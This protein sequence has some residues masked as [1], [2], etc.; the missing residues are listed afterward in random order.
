MGHG[1][2][3]VLVSTNSVSQSVHNEKIV[4]MKPRSFIDP[5]AQISLLIQHWL[6]ERIDFDRT[7]DLNLLTG[8]AT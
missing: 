7:G 1:K 2:S 6:T 3:E 5:S 4:S 8:E